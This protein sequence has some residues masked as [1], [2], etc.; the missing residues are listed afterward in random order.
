MEY[1]ID[2]WSKYVE[3]FEMKSYEKA[4]LLVKT[5]RNQDKN[6]FVAIRDLESKLNIKH[7]FWFILNTSVQKIS[8]K[9][10]HENT[11]T[12]NKDKF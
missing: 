4:E 11:K 12:K 9:F 8:L 5:T 6:T 1:R 2:I 10:I 3:N 7:I